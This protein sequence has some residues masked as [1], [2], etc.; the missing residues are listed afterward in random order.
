MSET[1]FSVGG[2]LSHLGEHVRSF[3]STSMAMTNLD[4]AN[5]ALFIYY[6]SRGV[7]CFVRRIPSQAIGVYHGV[8]WVENIEELLRPLFAFPVLELLS[9]SLRIGG[10]AGIDEHQTHLC[11]RN[12]RSRSD[13]IA[14]LRVA[15]KVVRVA[16]VEPTTCGFGG[17]HSIQLSYTRMIDRCR[18]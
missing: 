3:G 16:G 4:R 7:G 6:E 2:H 15:Q 18:K 14:H 5:D 12:A 13:E 17:R 1:D 10:R 9:M 8:V 11:L